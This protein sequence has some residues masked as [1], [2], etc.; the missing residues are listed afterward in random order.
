MWC[1]CMIRR[2]NVV[3]AAHIFTSK[4]ESNVISWS[5]VRLVVC[6]LRLSHRYEGNRQ[7]DFASKLQKLTVWQFFHSCLT[8]HLYRKEG[9]LGRFGSDL[10]KGHA[11][12]TNFKGTLCMN[13]SRHCRSSSDS[14]ASAEPWRTRHG[15]C[16]TE[17]KPFIRLNLCTWISLKVVRR[18]WGI[19]F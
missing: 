9:K 1:L 18:S 14:E 17:W 15:G 3:T 5:S 11:L 6:V 13:V 2:V 12:M 16:Q 7:F 8:L 19:F 4:T 10:K